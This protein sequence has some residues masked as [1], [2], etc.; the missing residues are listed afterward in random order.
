ML[1]EFWC[2]SN[3]EKKTLMGGVVEPLGPPLGSPQAASHDYME[4]ITSHCDV[5]MALSFERFATSGVL[6]YASS[7]SC[8]FLSI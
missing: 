2:Q 6:P 3:S 5:T 7:C 8:Y 1:P 4:A